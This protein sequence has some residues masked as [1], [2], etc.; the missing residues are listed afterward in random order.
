MERNGLRH[1]Q[2]IPVETV[3]KHAAVTANVDWW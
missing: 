2:H 3:A 1:V